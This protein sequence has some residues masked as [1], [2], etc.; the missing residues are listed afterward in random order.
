MQTQK[1]ESLELVNVLLLQ[2][3]FFS[4]ETVVELAMVYYSAVD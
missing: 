4:N 1:H 3:K 2:N